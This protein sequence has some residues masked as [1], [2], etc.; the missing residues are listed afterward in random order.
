MFIISSS[1]RLT[2]PNCMYVKEEK[3][4]KLEMII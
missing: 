4:R 1:P 3:N 2:G